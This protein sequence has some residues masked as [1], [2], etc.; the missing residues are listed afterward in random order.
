M[1][2]ECIEGY[3]QGLNRTGQLAL[4]ISDDIEAEDIAKS[5]VQTFLLRALNI[6]VESLK[7]LSQVGDHSIPSVCFGGRKDVAV[8]GWRDNGLDASGRVGQEV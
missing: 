8:L 7:D 5:S 3:V 1:R 2:F 4:A 6:G